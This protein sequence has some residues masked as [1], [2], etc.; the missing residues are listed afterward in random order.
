MRPPPAGKSCAG[1]GVA[2]DTALV[3][4]LFLCSTRARRAPSF[5]KS[6]LVVWGCPALLPATFWYQ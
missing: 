2:A 4:L 3:L 5:G 1:R 6:L